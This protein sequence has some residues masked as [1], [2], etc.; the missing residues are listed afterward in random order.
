MLKNTYWPADEEH[1]E[2]PHNWDIANEGFQDDSQHTMELRGKKEMIIPKFP[3]H[4]VFLPL[5]QVSTGLHRMGS[6]QA[7][8]LPCDQLPLTNR[9]EA[10]PLHSTLQ[11]T[12]FLA[13][14]SV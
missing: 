6:A 12:D 8:F 3:T 2:R 7:L 11:S 5:L 13:C 10:T 9:R 1:G 4:A 14:A